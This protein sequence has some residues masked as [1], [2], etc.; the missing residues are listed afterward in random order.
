MITFSYNKRFF[1]PKQTRYFALT[2][3]I[4]N[5][6]ALKGIKDGKLFE[7]PYSTFEFIRPLSQGLDLIKR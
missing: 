7:I 5:L 2:G 6:L 1:L 3:A 4:S